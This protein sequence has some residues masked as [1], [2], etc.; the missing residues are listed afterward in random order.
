MTYISSVNGKYNLIRN[1]ETKAITVASSRPKPPIRILS[2]LPWLIWFEYHC[3][4]TAEK[5]YCHFLMTTN[6]SKQTQDDI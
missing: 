4:P 5:S 2:S 1:K 3:R 6:E